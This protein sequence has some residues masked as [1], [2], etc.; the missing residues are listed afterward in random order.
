M[1]NYITHDFYT[2]VI[3]KL[4]KFPLVSIDRINEKFVSFTFEADPQVC[5]KIK[6]D[7]WDR[8]QEMVSLRDFVDEIKAVKSLIYEK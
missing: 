5:E 2:A 6:K 7:Y 3:L 8:K 1:K 4:K